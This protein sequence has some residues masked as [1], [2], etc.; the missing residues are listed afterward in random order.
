MTILF[1]N[2]E[3]CLRGTR[4]AVDELL[5]AV[6]EAWFEREFFSRNKQLSRKVKNCMDVAG[7]CIEK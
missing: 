4:F 1:R 5:E 3:Y 2:L 7:V 6:V